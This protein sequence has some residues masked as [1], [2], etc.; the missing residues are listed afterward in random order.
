MLN[1]EA[2]N[3]RFVGL[4]KAILKRRNLFLVLMVLVLAF[5]VYGLKQLKTDTDDSHYFDEGDALLVAKDYMASIFG[6]DNFCAVLVETDNVFTPKVLKGIR[7][8]GKELLD[9][10]P[11][12][13]DVVSVTDMEFTQG[14]EEGLDVSDIVPSVIPE[15]P[16][17]LEKIRSAIM[18]KPS[19]KDRLVSEDGRYAWIMLRLKNIP[20]GTV[21]EH[22]EFIE[23][24]IGRKVNEIAGQEKYAYMHPQTTGW[25]VINLE[26]RNFMAKEMPRLIGLSLLFVAVVLTIVLRSVRGVVFPLFLGGAGLT[27]VLGMQGLLGISTDPMVMLMPIFLS[28]SMAICYSLYFINFFRWEFQRTGLRRWSLEHAT[29]DT[30]WPI[31]F[32]A[33]TT[34]VSLLSFC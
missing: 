12:A 3:E 31:F 32:S 22:G 4:S 33:F 25:P 30:G 10:V 6:N 9:G 8:M 19:L 17:A 15:S 23:M 20:D 11:Y 29:G 18:A 34:A 1:I 7:E 5:S 28:L 21:D 2:I 13:D 27:I 16:E 24:V 26:K 14:T